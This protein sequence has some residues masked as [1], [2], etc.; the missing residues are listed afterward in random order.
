MRSAALHCAQ[1][2]PRLNV[3]SAKVA[4]P[5]TD[6]LPFR[7][8]WR[9]CLNF[10]RIVLV[11]VALGTTAYSSSLVKPELDAVLDRRSAY[12]VYLEGAAVPP[13][14]AGSGSILSQRRQMAACDDIMASTISK[15]MGKTAVGNVALGCKRRAAEIFVSSPTM[16]IAHLVAASAARIEGQTGKAVQHLAASQA[17]GPSEAWLATRRLRQAYML[18]PKT[19]GP[20][21]VADVRLVVQD[22]VYRR[23]VVDLYIAFPEDREWLKAA[24]EGSSRPDLQAVLGLIKD[25]MAPPND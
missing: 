14:F 5:A 18:G 22:E 12:D 7:P 13:A 11:S 19:A 1:R 20:A 9:C 24:L 16:A 4:I 21:A 17:A 25:E 3:K 15:L 23:E 8:L 6:A 2:L 10:Y